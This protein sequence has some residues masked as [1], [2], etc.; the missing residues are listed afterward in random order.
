VVMAR[1]TPMLGAASWTV[2]ALTNQSAPA[3]L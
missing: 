3:L 1:E 2:C